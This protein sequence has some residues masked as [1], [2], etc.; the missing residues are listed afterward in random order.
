MT[1]IKENTLYY[2]QTMGAYV[3]FRINENNIFIRYEIKPCFCSSTLIGLKISE[4]EKN[5]LTQTKDTLEVISGTHSL[6]DQWI[7]KARTDGVKNS[8]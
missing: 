1:E 2:N 3:Y 6:G 8:A 7:A 4:E 5:R